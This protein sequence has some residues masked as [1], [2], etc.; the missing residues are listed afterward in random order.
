MHDNSHNSDENV[1]EQMRL[2]FMRL[3]HQNP[4]EYIDSLIIHAENGLSVVSPR[5]MN[6]IGMSFYYG[7]HGVNKSFT[8][9]QKCFSWALEKGEAIAGLNLA[10]T[11]IRQST[12]NFDLAIQLFISLLENLNGGNQK[13][14][15][16]KN[17][18]YFF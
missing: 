14:Q 7:L 2:I 13:I 17:E 1:E 4:H 10:V 11:Y 12:P 16:R 6:K 15:K 8:L 18:I 9:A 5:A 3:R